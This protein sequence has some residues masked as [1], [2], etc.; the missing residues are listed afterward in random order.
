MYLVS[1]GHTPHVRQG[2]GISA[3]MSIRHFFRWPA[4][5]A[6][7]AAAGMFCFDPFFP[8]TGTPGKVTPLRATPEGVIQQLINSYEQLRIDLF[9]DLLPVSKTFQF[10]ISP[11]FKDA[12]ST[13][14]YVNPAEPRDTQLLYIGEDAKYYY[15]SQE[16]EVR[17]HKNLFGK[18]VSIV[19]KVKPDFNPGAFHYIIDSTGNQKD[20]TNVEMEVTNGEINIIADLGGVITELPPVAIERQVFFLERDEQH[21]WVIRKWYDFGRQP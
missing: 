9:E 15:W 8:P 14:S 20:T 11:S 21:L 5:I 18:A 3:I 19:F 7:A 13:K 17:S 16:T 4:F 1:R 10:Y 12:Y 2:R 6:A